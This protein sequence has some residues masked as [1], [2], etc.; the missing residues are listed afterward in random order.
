[1]DKILT[2]SRLHFFSAKNILFYFQAQILRGAFMVSHF[3]HFS[4]HFFFTHFAFNITL[5]FNLI[6]I[7]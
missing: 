6:T 5:D 7:I 4:Y 2:N 1:M 3:F